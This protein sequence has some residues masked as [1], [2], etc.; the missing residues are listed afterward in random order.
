MTTI[1]SNLRRVLRR[2]PRVRPTTEPVAAP[3]ERVEAPPVEIAPNDPLIAYFSGATGAVDIGALQLDSPALEGLR[4]AGIKLV[5]PLVSQGELIGLLNLGPRRSEQEYSAD[6]RK[7]LNDLAGHAAPAVR[8]AQ[9]VREQEA[10]VRQRE[11]IEQE[12]RVAQLIQQQF[13]P[14][15]L[16]DLPGWQVAAYYGPARE[17]GG[18]F[19]DFIKLP[20]DQIG[21]V[22][23]DVTDKGVPA[24]LVM[25]T[26]HSILRAEAPRLV[27]PS[28]VLTRVNNLLVEEMPAHMFVTC[29]YAV[30]DPASGRLRYANAG[31]NV[32]YVSTEGG[33]TELRATGMPLGL[34]PDMDYEEKE[35]TLAPGDTVLL[36]SDGLAEAH[37]PQ[38]EM[39]GF[40]LVASLTGEASDGEVLIDRLL[41]ELQEFTGPGVEQEDDITLVTIGRRAAGDTAAAPTGTAERQLAAFEVASEPGNERLA[42]DQVAEAVAGLGLA[43]Q[44]LERLKTAVGEAT[45]NAIEH[46][47]GNRP[48]LPVEV[49]VTTDDTDLK[50]RITDQGGDRGALPDVETPDLEAKLAGLQTPRGWGLFLIQNMVDRLETAVNEHHHTIELVMHLKEEPDARS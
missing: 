36:H 41:K 17:V 33:V 44:R 15:E 9:L 7:L 47:N 26:T 2:E 13:L 18:D 24:A 49:T 28:E 32:P 21:I 45:M 35:A 48:E 40:P 20:D 8:V 23:G 27:A 6:D 39:F 14:Q 12:L 37:N 3:P 50:V 29:L 10:E 19:Y 42:I 43:G 5:V 4:E 1:P 38:R 25:A 16:P 30:L 34:L 31:H 11:R 46:G 22:V